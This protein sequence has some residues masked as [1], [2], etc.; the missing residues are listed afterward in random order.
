[1]DTQ[2]YLKICHYLRYKKGCL[3]RR[4][5][6]RFLGYNA[7]KSKNEKRKW[8]SMCKS[9]ELEN[10]VLY[11]D[12]KEV[13]TKCTARRRIVRIHNKR[14]HIGFEELEEILKG[15]FYIPKRRKILRDLL[16]N[17][18]LCWDFHSAGFDG[19]ENYPLTKQMAKN[20]REKLF[21]KDAEVDI[22]PIQK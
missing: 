9:F 16:N 13:W 14:R 10:G 3:T 19:G 6:E 8:R 17:C 7:V 11:K 12:G 18:S 2:K 15:N 20:I 4:K 1:M 22:Y 5:N 21:L